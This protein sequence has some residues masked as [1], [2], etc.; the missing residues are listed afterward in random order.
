MADFDG[1]IRLM[2]RAF[3][4]REFCQDA[5][6]VSDPVS[7]IKLAY[8]HEAFHT[9]DLAERVTIAHDEK[10]SGWGMLRRLTG[11]VTLSLL[12]VVTLMII[13]SDNLATDFVLA[14]LDREAM[15]DRLKSLGL[16]NTWAWNG[17]GSS[18]EPERSERENETT[19]R[20]IVTLLE[21]IAEDERMME[22][23]SKQT[24]R[25]IIHHS[26][27]GEVARYTKSGQ[28][29]RLRNDAGI[30]KWEDGGATLALFG[31]RNT[32][33]KGWKGLLEYDMELAPI[34]EAAYL[35]ARI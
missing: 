9:L 24:D 5:D 1:E 21:H 31:V 7:V 2:V 14:R 35:W 8:L 3:D 6:V 30:L 29:A 22:V 32:D 11:E 33:I 18:C 12:D 19:P 4:G 27:P 25:T 17:F 20:D 15:N 16:T 10:A 13:Y 23:L 28:C 34:A 26:V